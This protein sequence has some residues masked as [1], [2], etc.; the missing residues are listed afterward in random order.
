MRTLIATAALG[1]AAVL[2]PVGC[3]LPVAV[4]G[5][6]LFMTSIGEACSTDSA[7]TLA[8]PALHR[9]KLESSA[10]S[11]PSTSAIPTPC[12]SPPSALNASEVAEPAT[13]PAPDPQAEVAVASALAAIGRGGHY[14][15]EGN[16]PTD[17]DCSGLT[18]WAWRQAGVSLVDYSYTQRNQTRD[19]PRALVQPGDLVFWFGG[20]EHHVAIV[21]AVHNGQITI[22]EAANPEA[23]LRTRL[24]G[25]GWDNAYL[26]GFGRVTRA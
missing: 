24:L 19:I 21:T 25:G 14:I 12:S 9:H 4:A 7:V 15:A 20:A 13:I 11:L 6:A 8:E 3:L 1:V 16:G 22:A 18:A 26:T 5:S 23:G 2:L 17:F 10:E